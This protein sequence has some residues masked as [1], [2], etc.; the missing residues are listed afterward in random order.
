MA[1]I[2]AL[3][4]PGGMRALIC[5]LVFTVSCLIGCV[6]PPGP[7][8]KLTNAAYDMNTAT[9]FGRMD[10]A[11]SHVVAHAREDFLARHRKWG[12]DM[13]IVD[14]EHNGLRM[15]TTDTAAVTLAVSWHPQNSSTIRTSY[16]VQKWRSTGDGWQLAIEQRSSGDPGVFTAPPEKKKPIDRGA[17]GEVA[18]GQL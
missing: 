15:V 1:R 7:M 17:E 13:R 16:I 8:E 14:V 12:K 10:I 3:G 6:P 5:A 9:R 18:T 11:A 2:R 4:Y